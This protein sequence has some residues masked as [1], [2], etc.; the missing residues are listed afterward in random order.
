MLSLLY[1]P[2]L[3]S[4]YDYWKNNSFDYTDLCGQI[5]GFIAQSEEFSK[6]E[7]YVVFLSEETDSIIS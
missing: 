6:K 3:I 5:N 1:D 2:T 7:A 4:V